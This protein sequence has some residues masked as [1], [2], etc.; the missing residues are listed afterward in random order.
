MHQNLI[1]NFNAQNINNCSDTR[2]LPR[3]TSLVCRLQ[4]SRL[5]KLKALYKIVLLLLLQMYLFK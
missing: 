3:L 5:Q 1:D 4:R 2:R